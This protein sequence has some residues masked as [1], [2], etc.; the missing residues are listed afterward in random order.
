VLSVALTSPLL[1]FA[2]LL[3]VGPI[4]EGPLDV[5]SE[6]QRVVS[7]QALGEL[8]VASLE[9]LDDLKVIDDR[10]LDSVL[11]ANRVP[12]DGAHVYEQ[13]VGHGGDQVRMSEFE[14]P[15]VKA[16]VQYQILYA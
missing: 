6:R 15:L 9:G 7:N 10:A 4:G 1:P 14:D 5:P 13:G 3:P 2:W 11:F 12:A 8:G 16:Q